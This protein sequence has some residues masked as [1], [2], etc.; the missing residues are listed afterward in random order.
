MR[1]EHCRAVR[2]VN[3][4]ELTE[5]QKQAVKKGEA[6]RVSAPELGE[7]ITVLRADIY[8]DVREIVEEERVRRL[9]ASVAARNAAS[10]M[11]DE[12]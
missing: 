3:M 12:P 9:L 4:I 11:T 1:I 5:E 6:V 8:E 10:R 7:A 2:E